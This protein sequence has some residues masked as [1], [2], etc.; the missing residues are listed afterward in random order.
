MVKFQNRLASFSRTDFDRVFR[1][2]AG[3]GFQFRASLN[4]AKCQFCL[5]SLPNY[6]APLDPYIVHVKK[7][8]DADFSEKKWENSGL[9]TRFEITIANTKI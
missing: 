3:A 9:I 7:T 8:D 4:I 6:L 2:L 5:T 1:N